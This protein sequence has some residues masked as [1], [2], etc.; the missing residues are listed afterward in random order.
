MSGCVGMDVRASASGCVGMDICVSMSG[1][2]EIEVASVFVVLL[3]K[4][5]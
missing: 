1:C 2:V 5:E 4:V 3:I